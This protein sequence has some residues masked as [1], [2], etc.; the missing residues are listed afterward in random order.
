VGIRAR[1]GFLALCLA[2]LRPPGSPASS[3][4]ALGTGRSWSCGSG[5]RGGPSNDPRAGTHLLGELGLV[6]LGKRRIQ[7]DLRAAAST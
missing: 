5:A 6:S 4:G 3:S 7:G 2:L 1:R